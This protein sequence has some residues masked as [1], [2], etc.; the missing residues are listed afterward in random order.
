[1]VKKLSIIFFLSSVILT[2]DTEQLYAQLPIIDSVFPANVYVGSLITIK[3]SNMNY[4]ASVA[5]GA[6]NALIVAA[7]DSQLVIMVM[8][9]TVTGYGI[10]ITSFSGGQDLYAGQI[11][12]HA[13]TP[14]VN[15]LG[16]KLFDTVFCRFAGRFFCGDKCGW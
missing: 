4:A 8:P 11:I 14:P 12:V 10:K 1:M 15:Q 2:G 3:G 9:G 5:I 6:V 16:N 13:S 7:E